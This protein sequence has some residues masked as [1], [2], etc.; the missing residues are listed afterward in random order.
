MLVPFVA[1]IAILVSP[2]TPTQVWQAKYDHIVALMRKFDF[3]GYVAMFHPQYNES[4]GG[5]TINLAQAK[6][7]FTE[8]MNT[9]A[10]YG[11][12][13]KV[14]DVREIEQTAVV[15]VVMTFER[16]QTVKGKAEIL[17]GEST[18]RD[19]WL[20]DGKVFKLY[21]SA[22]IASVVKKNGKVLKPGKGT[23]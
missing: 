15:T 7:S 16:K 4:A 18:V 3:A 6:Q 8:R 19:T 9:I 2:P 13:P 14:L 21:R 12:R 22:T 1:G 10:K 5:R 20:K 17:T 11:K 23:Q